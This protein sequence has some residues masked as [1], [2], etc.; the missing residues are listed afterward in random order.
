MYNK[1]IISAALQHQSKEIA[2]AFLFYL[3]SIGFFTLAVQYSL[4]WL[5]I[6][7]PFLILAVFLT[8]LISVQIKDKLLHFSKDEKLFNDGEHKLFFNNTKNIQYLLNISQGVRNGVFEEYHINGQLKIKS[9]YLNGKL[10]KDYKSFHSNGELSFETQYKNGIQYGE[11]TSFYRSGNL[12]RSFSLIEGEYDGEIKEYFD[13]PDGNLKFMALNDLYTVYNKFQK[14]KCIIQLKGAPSGRK[15]NIRD[16][17]RGEGYH[18]IWK[19]YRADGLLDYEL[20]FENTDIK[21]VD[22]V[23]K[24][25]YNKSGDIVTKKIFKYQRVDG[26]F[27]LLVNEY[28]TKRRDQKVITMKME[29]GIKGPPGLNFREIWSIEHPYLIKSLDQLITLY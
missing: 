4:G 29:T 26:G 22:E 5:F 9:N 2:F 20:D 16:G 18:G 25:T 15:V 3:T 21:E 10:N 7:V 14:I 6:C 23:L 11:T 17:Y 12:F 24:I 27:A 1:K 28:A 8:Y 13:S 19:S